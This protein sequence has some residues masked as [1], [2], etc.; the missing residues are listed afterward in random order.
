MPPW[1]WAAIGAGLA[2]AIAAGA[3]L[4][5]WW[6][7]REL[8]R[9]RGQ[10]ERTEI[11]RDVAGGRAAVAEAQTEVLEDHAERQEQAADTA[12]EIRDA[13][14]AA[15]DPADPDAAL[16]AAEEWVRRRHDGGA[17]ADAR[18]RVTATV[19]PAPTTKAR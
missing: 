17:G 4:A 8:A 10:L 5:S 16:R 2:A 11:E 9:V 12:E 1:V 6:R 3:K 15:A 7:G 14:T 18:P 19:R 13:A